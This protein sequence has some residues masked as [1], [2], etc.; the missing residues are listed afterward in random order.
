MRTKAQGIEIEASRG[1]AYWQIGRLRFAPPGM[2]CLYVE[3]TSDPQESADVALIPDEARQLA[4]DL[5][6]LADECEGKH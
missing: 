4:A 2:I 5:L 3:N 1:V 6:R